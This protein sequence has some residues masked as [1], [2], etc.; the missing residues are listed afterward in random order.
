LTYKIIYDIINVWG[1]IMK[2]YIVETEAK[3]HPEH[4]NT[5]TYVILANNEKEVREIIKN[6]WRGLKVVSI[7]EKKAKK[8]LF[9]HCE[10]SEVEI[11]HTKLD[12]L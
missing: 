12:V 9:T 10:F 6:D 2:T 8:P 7:K 5:P 4:W 3:E 11:G 1:K